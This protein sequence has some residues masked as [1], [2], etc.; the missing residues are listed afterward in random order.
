MKGFTLTELVIVIGV[1]A[2]LSSAILYNY[3]RSRI[4]ARDTQRQQI[5][6]AIQSTLERYY[7]DFG[8]YPTGNLCTALSASLI[9]SPADPGCGAG[10]VTY[11][12]NC[13]S[14]WVPCLYGSVTYSYT[15]GAGIYTMIL[16]REAGGV[17][18]FV[19]PQ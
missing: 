4:T 15:A 14:D 8:S 3:G 12:A 6:T 1:I 17:V 16:S 2:V 13:A 7:G 5:V 18:T 10:A 19:S 9:G 11:P